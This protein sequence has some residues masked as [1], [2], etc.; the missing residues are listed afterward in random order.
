MTGEDTTVILAG[1][2][3]GKTKTLIARVADL[4]QHDNIL[5][6]QVAVVSFTVKSA[7]EIKSRVQAQL[8][9]DTGDMCIGTIHALARKIIEAASGQKPRLHPFAKNTLQRRAWISNQIK[10]LLKADAWLRD[11]IYEHWMNIEFSR[12]SVE[13]VNKL[14]PEPLYRAAGKGETALL[15]SKAESAVALALWTHRIEY[16]YEREMPIPPSL[17]TEQEK[18]Y[19][20]DF[21][22]PREKIWIEVWAFGDDGK[23]PPDWAESEQSEYR[24]TYH[25]KHNVH[26]EMGTRLVEV[27]AG[28]RWTCLRRGESF[29]D[30]VLTRIS[31][32]TDHPHAWLKEQR[33][34]RRPT[35]EI[36][37]ETRR[38]W[39]DYEI[40]GLSHDIDEW[41]TTVRN[42]R[43]MPQERWR[44]L[45]GSND[46][47]VV[48]ALWAIGKRV[49][50]RYLAELR[51]SGQPDY[52]AQIEWA[53]EALEER[54]ASVPWS[55][56]LVDEYQ[57]T[58]PLQEDLLHAIV[59]GFEHTSE[60]GLPGRL[61]VVGDD[62]QAIYGF[63][64]SDV[65]RIRKLWHDK[66]T[67]KIA[68]KQTY[69]FGAAL[70][71]LSR[72]F[73]CRDPRA[74]DKELLGHADGWRDP[75]HPAPVQ[76]MT[77]TL[78]EKGLQAARQWI[79]EVGGG[80]KTS[81]VLCV[82]KAIGAHG[83]ARHDAHGLRPRVMILARRRNTLED[84]GGSIGEVQKEVMS[85]W[86]EKRGSMPE[87]AR[88]SETA[89]KTC[90]R[91]E[92]GKR[93]AAGLDHAA[94]RQAGQDLRLEVDLSTRTIHGAKGLEADYV[95]LVDPGGN[96][97]R[98]A[99]ESA[100]RKALEPFGQPK[101][102]SAEERRVW[103]VA[104]TRTRRKVYLVTAGQTQE[105]APLVE[106]LLQQTS[107][108]GSAVGMDELVE[109]CE[110]IP[111][112]TVECPRCSRDAVHAS[113]AQ[114]V[115]RQGP[116]GAFAGC[117][118]Y[119]DPTHECRHAES[120]CP[121][122]N[123]ALVQ[124]IGESEGQCSSPLCGQMVELCECD[125]PMPMKIRT[126]VKD[127]TRF[128]GC[129]RYNSEG[130]RH[131]KKTKN[132]NARAYSLAYNSKIF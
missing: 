32:K 72:N 14:E 82:L 24:R 132:I 38:L 93:M 91:E 117:T 121:F 58:N 108:P 43:F 96:S 34:R 80:D 53:I 67:A 99:S 57:D 76:S 30:L 129:A 92:A 31:E 127:K 69:R 49:M 110:L 78:G 85:G 107:E 50:K 102:A 101:D 94:I 98:R 17:G 28:D 68:L 73:V 40:N 130:A 59:N 2:G 20:P 75:H 120:L 116:H 8:D 100:L 64:G 9:H 27:R 6:E 112:V 113:Q 74:L 48:G 95:V 63:Q 88:G 19:H 10:D 71:E 65:E 45:I 81:A 62:W 54:Q 119:G 21:Y 131:C 70:A 44:H 33:S 125:P 41:M 123:K 111:S 35:E 56:L 5:P 51:E 39:G 128:W 7:E 118:G 104:L 52:Q 60:G 15:R 89:M 124:R 16:E 29:A 105:A 13:T 42:R 55:E 84:R 23:L 122:C 79:G 61:W 114:L 25:W 3:T 11:A 22:L 4:L 26:R 1:A 77:W 115:I 86:L 12:L 103:Y 90:A 106:E 47:M 109:F 18:S 87:E 37:A 83:R 126:N 46:P 66:R 97:K 36:G